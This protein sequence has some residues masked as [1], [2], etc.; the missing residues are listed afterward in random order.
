MELVSHPAKPQKPTQ[1]FEMTLLIEPEL[2]FGQIVLGILPPHVT[3]W[4]DD[5]KLRPM[6]I[7]GVMNDGNDTAEIVPL[8][9]HCYRGLH[10]IPN[11]WNHLRKA[12]EMITDTRLLF[13]RA[14]RLKQI[15]VL[16]PAEVVKCRKI[17]SWTSVRWLHK[18]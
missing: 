17:L 15:G 4:E 2:S 12:C 10:L 13:T 1:T 6:L 7:T 9:S 5:R 8:S 3:C 18:V 14:N 16:T 11:E